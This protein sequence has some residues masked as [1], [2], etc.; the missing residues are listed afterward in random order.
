VR[1]QEVWEDLEEEES[2]LMEQE[3][4]EAA[5]VVVVAR[6]VEVEE[7]M[8]QVPQV[9]DLEEEERSVRSLSLIMAEHSMYKM[10]A[11]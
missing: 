4:L 11:L 5:G 6:K 3:D 1:I 2:E 9:A 8:V 7:V 10:V